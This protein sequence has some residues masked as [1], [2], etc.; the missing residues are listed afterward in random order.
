MK[1]TFEITIDRKRIV[2]YC[3]IR[4]DQLSPGDLYVA[5]RNTGWHL[6]KCKYVDRNGGW[7]MPEPPLSIY[8]YD[9]H[10][11]AKVKEINIIGGCGSVVYEEDGYVCPYFSRHGEWSDMQGSNGFC[12]VDLQNGT[13]RCLYAI[14]ELDLDV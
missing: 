5:K 2:A 4:G 13:N 9:C 12:A 6:A 8:S 7:V 10:E 14:L 11:C 3:D 1:D